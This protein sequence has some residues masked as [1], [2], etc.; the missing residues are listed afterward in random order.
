MFK[1]GIVWRL[2]RGEVCIGMLTREKVV[3]PGHMETYY[4]VSL[5]KNMKDTLKRG[6]LLQ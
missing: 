6:A 3:R 4:L 1:P 2:R 5:L